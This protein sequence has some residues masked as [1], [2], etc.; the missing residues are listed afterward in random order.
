MYTVSLDLS[1]NWVRQGERKRDNGNFQVGLPRRRTRNE[2]LGAIDLIGMGSQGRSVLDRGTRKRM[3]WKK[4]ARWD[5]QP[6]LS[7]A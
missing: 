1:L 5:L 3:D 7:P 2:E 4:L 6:S